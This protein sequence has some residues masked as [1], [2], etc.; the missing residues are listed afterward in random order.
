MR[1]KKGFDF[2]ADSNT[3]AKKDSKIVHNMTSRTVKAKLSVLNQIKYSLFH[4]RGH[5]FS[6]FA[7]FGMGLNI[8]WRAPRL[9]VS[10]CGKL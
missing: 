5:F 4:K 9:N 7:G 6:D 8:Y 2:R 1:E 3:A 10:L